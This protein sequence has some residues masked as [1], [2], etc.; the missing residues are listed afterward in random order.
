MLD[1]LLAVAVVLLPTLFALAVEIVSKEIKEHPY[2]R[3]AVLAFGI[4]LSALTWFQLS[5]AT[6]E[7][8]V[9]REAAIQETSRKVS[10]DVSEAVSKSVS[11]SVADQYTQTIN[12]LQ[13]QIGTLQGQLEKQGQSV[14][15]I[16]SSNFVSGKSPVKVEVTNQPSVGTAPSPNAGPNIRVS[17][18]FVDAKKEYGKMA[19][20][21]ILTTDRVMNGGR[22]RFHCDN[23][24]NNGIAQISGASAMMGASGRDDDHTF[25]AEIEAPN[26]SPNFPLVV[27]LYADADVGKCEIS[28]IE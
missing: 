2:W 17:R 4:G 21:F 28:A 16:K 22:A 19:I 9:D 11:K 20:Q 27:T 10:G 6:K 14:E 3:A 1:Q 24:I 8:A 25:T 15:A 26:W 12:T 5:R 13:T 23:K 18:M 7:A